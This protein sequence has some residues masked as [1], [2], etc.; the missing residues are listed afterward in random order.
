MSQ[1]VELV[2]LRRY[3]IQSTK[4]HV[5]CLM[6]TLQRSSERLRVHFGLIYH[7]LLSDFG[8]NKGVQYVCLVSKVKCQ[9]VVIL[10]QLM[11]VEVN[12]GKSEMVTES[13]KLSSRVKIIDNNLNIG[14]K[15]IKK[16]H[17]SYVLSRSNSNYHIIE[18]V[19]TA[20]V[21]TWQ[22]A[23]SIINVLTFVWYP[24]P[25]ISINMV[26]NFIKLNLALVKC[27]CT[28]FICLSEW[29]SMF[30]FIPLLFQ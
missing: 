7:V 29:R 13:S 26:F 30:C 23:R 28:S 27:L 14:D 10:L 22:N 16:N 20:Q 3:I 6:Q 21:D 1:G 12:C 18:V 19:T 25:N 8:R 11:N 24:K 5:Y 9:I 2:S 17:D 4:L 15:M